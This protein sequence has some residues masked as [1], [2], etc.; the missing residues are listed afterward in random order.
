MTRTLALRRESLTL[1]TGDELAAVAGG[2]PATTGG[3]VCEL[4]RHTGP[5]RCHTGTTTEYN[6]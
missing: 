5:I 3:D 1:L 6:D 4:I 2:V